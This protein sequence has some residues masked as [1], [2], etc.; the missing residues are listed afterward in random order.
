MIIRGG[1]NIAPAEVEAVLQCAPGGRG[2]GGRRACR[3][4]VGAARRRRSSCCGPGEHATAD[5]LGEFCRAAAGELQEAR[6]DP[7]PP[8]AAEEPDGQGA[9]PRAAGPARGRVTRAA[10]GARPPAVETRGRAAASRG[11]RSSGR[12]RG[13]RLDAELMGALAEACETRGAR[14][15]RCAWS[16]SSAAGHHFCAGLPPALAWP[17][18]AWPDGDRARRRRHASRWSACLGE[19][20][21]RLGRRAGARLRP[22]ARG[23]RGGARLDAVAATAGFRAAA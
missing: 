1:E 5:E 16:C 10:R 12:R 8:R 3:R 7:L 6:G 4:R 17:P 22:P 23:D 9:A 15:R 20:R 18:T 11:S 2:G 21:Q 14:R 13:N 19:A